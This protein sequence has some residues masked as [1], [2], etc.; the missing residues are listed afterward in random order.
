MGKLILTLDDDDLNSLKRVISLTNVRR[1]LTKPGKRRL[2]SSL[3]CTM[4]EQHLK[5]TIK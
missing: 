5:L 3:I 4:L 1:K 2:T